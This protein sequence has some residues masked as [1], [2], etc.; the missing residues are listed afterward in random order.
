MRTLIEKMI[1]RADSDRSKLLIVSS[2]MLCGMVFNHVYGNTC[3]D[4]QGILGGA[5]SSILII[6]LN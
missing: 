6:W 3:I 2:G 4:P 1:F 5:I